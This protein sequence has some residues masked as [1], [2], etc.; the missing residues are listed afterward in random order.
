MAANNQAKYIKD[1]HDAIDAAAQSLREVSLKIHSNPELG[2]K[3][4]IAHETLT[5]YMES[6]GFKVKRHACEIDTAFVA[7]FESPA[8]RAAEQAGQKIHTIGFCSEFDALPSVGH[9]CG[10]N[11]IAISGVAAAIGVKVA[12]EKNNLPGR[13]RLLGTPAEETTGGKIPMLERGAFD[14]LAACMMLH[15][16]QTDLVYPITLGVGGFLV[17]YHGKSSHASAS[18]WEGVNALD[19]MVMAYNG[20]SML[21][22]QT[23][24]SSRIHCII[25]DGGKAANII[26]DY[27]S[28]KIMY[29]ATNTKDLAKVHNDVLRVI[30][31][32]AAA[33]GCTVTVHKEMEYQ[34]LPQNEILG[35][36]YTQYLTEAGVRFLSRAEQ[37]AIPTGS[38]DMGNIANALPVIHPIFNIDNLDSITNVDLTN[39]SYGFTEQ[40]KTDVAHA[41]T[42]RAAKG[43]ALVGLDVIVE[44]GF[45][46]AVRR[47][48]EERVVAVQ[49]EAPLA[50]DGVAPAHTFSGACGCHST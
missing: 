40:S 12:L 5:N 34:S 44:P 47:N 33:T 22:Q 13:V 1:V 37:E 4:V 41:A 26:P 23:L 6:Q 18:P 2:Y 42:F 43:M 9:A 21:R 11:L 35:T 38:T 19:A 14:G 8:T 30:H 3:E 50:V 27:A 7:E 25:L 32:A 31:A 49:P 48:F 10:H 46:E 39:H 45:A 16:F 28:G 20:L 36:R 15:P 17:E 24:S 29:R